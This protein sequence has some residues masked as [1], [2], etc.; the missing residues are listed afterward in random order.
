DRAQL[1]QEV[2]QLTSE[3]NRVGNTT[4]FNTQ[5]LL[6]GNKAGEARVETIPAVVEAKGEMTFDVDVTADVTI[7]GTKFTYKA[8]PTD[9]KTE[10]K[11][12]ATLVTA[13]GTNDSTKDVYTASAS[14][15]KLKLVQ[16][17]GSETVASVKDKTGKVDVKFDTTK[18]GKAAK[19]EEKIN[20]EG[21]VKLQVGS[22]EH[23]SMSIEIGDMRSKALGISGDA[24]G[25]AA[26]GGKFTKTTAVTDGTNDA[27]TEAGLDLSSHANATA[28]VKI[29]DSAINTVSTQRSK[30]G[31]Y[32]NR[33]EHT[34]NNLN[35]SSENLQASESRIRDVD[36][37]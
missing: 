30:L 17:V 7:N 5:K 19:A 2:N 26:D 11:D 28:A 24:D 3:I 18:E 34:I 22:N 20:I 15:A 33:L 35:T 32:Q 21:R 25:D 1:Q 36:M 10:F 9:T 16:K 4:E 8:T 12:L 37:A 23:Q 29:L 31:A 14:G 13:I 27:T 6:N